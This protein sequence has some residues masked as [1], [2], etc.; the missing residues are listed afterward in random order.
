VR[1]FFFGL[2]PTLHVAYMKD[3]G[4]KTQWWVFQMQFALKCMWGWI[5]AIHS[6]SLTTE[7]SG[8][9]TSSYIKEV[10]YHP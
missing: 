5:T 4:A 7:K 6:P 10:V 9:F 8:Y 2:D 1:K 3:L